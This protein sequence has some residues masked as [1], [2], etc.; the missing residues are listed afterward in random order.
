MTS[1]QMR[2]LDTGDIVRGKRSAQAFVVTGN[3]GDHVTA[4]RTVDITNSDEWDLILKAKHKGV[5]LPQ[6]YPPQF[7][8]YSQE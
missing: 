4:V 8:S 6:E 5:K 7:T 1:E 2:N 3:Y